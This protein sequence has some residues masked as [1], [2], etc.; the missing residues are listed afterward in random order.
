[1]IYTK[2]QCM[3]Q[4]LVVQVAKASEYFTN[5]WVQVLGKAGEIGN[6][7]NDDSRCSGTRCSYSEHRAH[8][9]LNTGAPRGFN[10]SSEYDILD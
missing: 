3:L 9:L 4:G 1:M 10:E 5:T 2:L 6:T 8:N 7:L